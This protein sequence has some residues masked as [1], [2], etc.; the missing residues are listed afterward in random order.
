MGDG[1]Q[2]PRD[3]PNERNQFSADDNLNSIRYETFG[4]ESRNSTSTGREDND[5]KTTTGLNDDNNRAGYL[6]FKEGVFVKAEAEKPNGG[7]EKKEGNPTREMLDWLGKNFD[8]LDRSKDG[9]LTQAELGHAVLDPK[10][11]NGEGAAYIATAYIG[12]K[13][14]SKAAAELSGKKIDPKSG[15]DKGFT[16]EDLKTVGDNL[17]RVNTKDFKDRMAITSIIGFREKVDTNQDGTITKSELSASLKRTDLT[18]DQRNSLQLLQKRFSEVAKASDDKVPGEGGKLRTLVPQTKDGK[19]DTREKEYVS[20]KD[21]SDFTRTGDQLTKG[22]SDSLKHRQERLNEKDGQG[23]TGSCFLLA[24]AQSLLAKDPNALKSMIK[25]NKD[26]TS[27]VTFPAAE[28]PVTVTNPTKAELAVYSNGKDM[29]II[30]KAFAEK[31]IDIE[32]TGGKFDGSGGKNKVPPQEVLQRGGS[33]REALEYLTGK[34]A[35]TFETR[36]SNLPD[37]MKLANSKDNVMVADS[38]KGRDMPRGTG[39]VADHAYALTGFD[40]KTG[41][42]ELMNPNTKSPGGRLV[43]PAGADG[44]AKDGANDGKF[45]MPLADFR[46]SF[47]RIRWASDKPLTAE[48]RKDF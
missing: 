9:R 7:G 47:E 4:P 22:L 31:R 6:D 1:D 44:R 8:K 46:K 43:E 38:K 33:S 34:Q 11:G 26:G 48:Q 12:S 25:D 16:R 42:V 18:P 30:E 40:Q 20:S 35:F 36:A 2:F 21:L 27:T 15:E 39:I 13:D 3:K 28:Q 29:A 17:E 10:L 45:Q 37:Y 41:M 19:T 14:I 32:R 24:S 23:H 5:K